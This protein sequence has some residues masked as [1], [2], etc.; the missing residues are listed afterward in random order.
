MYRHKIILI[1]HFS[2]HK[3]SIVFNNSCESYANKANPNDL[4]STIGETLK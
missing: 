2:I 1:K 4:L 3:N